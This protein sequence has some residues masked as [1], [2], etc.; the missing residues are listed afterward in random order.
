MRLDRIIGP[1]SDFRCSDATF[2]SDEAWFQK[3]LNNHQ[4]RA[5]SFRAAVLYFGYSLCDELRLQCPQYWLGAR[6]G[7]VAS[8]ARMTMG[9]ETMKKFLL[10][11]VGLVALGMAAPASAADM[12]YKAPPPAPYVAPIYDWTGFYIGGNGGWGQSRNCV[13]FFDVTG[14]DFADGC[15]ERS[16]G[17]VGGQIGYRW[18]SG[19]WVFGLEAQGDWADLSNTRLSL[20]NP[21]V[22]DPHQNRWHRPVHRPDR[23][24]LECVA[25]LRQGRRGGD[26]ATALASLIH[27]DR[28]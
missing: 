2:A 17:L 22:L 14:F 6:V 1:P 24:R 27:A 19:T 15:R 13:D 11:T 26:R 10:G 18:Q 5:L 23:L 9:I 21:D 7:T 3:R 4:L 28:L 20:L 16:G 25:V 8:T 12:P